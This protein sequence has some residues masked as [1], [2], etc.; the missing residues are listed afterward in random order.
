MFNIRLNQTRK[1]KGYTAQQM[2]D[3]L[4]I[5]LRSYRLYESGHR[6][7]NLDTLVKIAI[8]LKFLWTTYFVVMIIQNPLENE[9]FQ[10]YVNR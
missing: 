8:F 1:A 3:K 7:P 2:A 4:T 9:T 10:K 6:S 5:G